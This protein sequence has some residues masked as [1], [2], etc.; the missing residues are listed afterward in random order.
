MQLP[1]RAWRRAGDQL[2]ENMPGC[3]AGHCAHNNQPPVADI[4]AGL[5][6]RSIGVG[7]QVNPLSAGVHLD[8]RADPA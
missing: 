6:A 5:A 8:S 4:P 1:V 3:G 2:V 7:G